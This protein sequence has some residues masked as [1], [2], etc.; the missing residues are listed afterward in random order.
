MN[1]AVS[2]ITDLHSKERLS[3]L[4]KNT[5]W[6]VTVM[7]SV[8]S[9][10]KYLKNLAR[11]GA[12]HGTV[13]LTEGQ[14]AGHGRFDR[15][16]YSPRHS[17]IYMSLLLRPKLQ[18]EE[19]L[20]ITAAAAVA[21]CRAVETLTAKKAHIKWV[22]DIL[23]DGKKLCGMLTEGSVSKDGYLEWAVLG[24]GINAY[25]PTEG[26]DQSIKDI[27]T[28]VFDSKKEG[29]R[30][31][32]TAT[33]INE[34]QK[35]YETLPEKDFLAEYKNRSCVLGH[36]VNVLKNGSTRPATALDITD[37]CE[38]LVSFDDGTTELLNSGEIS[39]KI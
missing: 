6:S 12:P 26:F 35:I 38:L 24:I 23:L 25:S 31:L 18:A 32:L 37:N 29:N 39:I 14:T 13:I 9:T 27:A 28:C 3:D 4:L 16:F 11:E 7:D 34:F 1:C 19:G 10:N 22:N 30:D 15:V 8:D 20:L 17:G 21:V 2:K 33:V 36:R 5:D